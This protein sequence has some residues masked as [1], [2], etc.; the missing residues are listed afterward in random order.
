MLRKNLSYDKILLQS[1]TLMSLSVPI[2]YN[3]SALSV[4]EKLYN[5]EL[6]NAEML[7]QGPLP[8]DWEDHTLEEFRYLELSMEEGDA[9]TSLENI[10]LNQS[11]TLTSFFASQLVD[12]PTCFKRIKSLY[13]STM[14]TPELRLITMI[15][16]HG[17]RSYVAKNYSQCLYK[18][19]Y[20]KWERNSWDASAGLWRLYYGAFAQISLS[21]ILNGPTVYSSPL[22]LELTDNYSQEFTK[23]GFL[24]RDDSWFQELLFL[25]LIQYT[26]VFTFFISKVDKLKR[27]HSRGKTGRYSIGW[28][29]I[30]KYKRLLIVLRWLVKDIRFQKSKTLNQRIQKSFENLMFDKSAH[31]VYQL[32][33]FVHRF[34]FQNYRKT[35]LKTLRSSS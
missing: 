12:V 19:S 5:R 26:P 25:E 9:D 4:S 8:K 11:V 14:S 32:R 20:L 2:V 35:L 1:E 24:A 10:F 23:D 34:V 16:R 13:S 15:M 33:N 6:F 22:A 3:Y 27:K 7:F 29:F 17:R 18:L 30:P 21:S 28:K 31:L